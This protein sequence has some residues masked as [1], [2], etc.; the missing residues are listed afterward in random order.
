VFQWDDGTVGLIG[1]RPVLAGVMLRRQPGDS[2]AAIGKLVRGVRCAREARL[3]PLS[4]PGARETWNFPTAAEEF[5]RVRR[6]CRSPDAGNPRLSPL[7]VSVREEILLLAPSRLPASP[8]KHRNTETPKHRNTETPKH[9]NT[10]L[11]VLCVFA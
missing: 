8:P 5:A 3:S 2:F 6:L 9:R 10:A 7:R 4:L 1:S 11:G